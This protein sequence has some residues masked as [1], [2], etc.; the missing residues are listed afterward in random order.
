MAWLVLALGAR[1]QNRKGSDAARQ[2]LWLCQ[3]RH[4]P[5]AASHRYPGA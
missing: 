5:S 2:A 4:D 1:S 3:E